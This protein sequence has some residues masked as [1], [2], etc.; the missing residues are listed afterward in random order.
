MVLSTWTHFFFRVSWCLSAKPRTRTKLERVD[1]QESS[2]TGAATRGCERQGM[3]GRG[4]KDT[5]GMRSSFQLQSPAS[6][7][8]FFSSRGEELDHKLAV[9]LLC[10]CLHPSLRRGTENS[11]V[12]ASCIVG[13][14]REY[15]TG[16]SES[17]WYR[18][19]S[20]FMRPLRS[21]FL[22]FKFVCLWESPQRTSTN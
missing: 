9:L 11:R 12:S 5:S 8:L 18:T 21:W 19:C 15:S 6:L 3:R 22:V 20:I 10:S 7:R 1:V 16:V 2:I 13:F 14:T 17:S 4:R